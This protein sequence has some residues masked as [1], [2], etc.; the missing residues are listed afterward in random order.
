MPVAIADLCRV[1]QRFAHAGGNQRRRQD[2]L[3]Q[4][5]QERAHHRVIGHA[6]TDRAAVR[7]LEPSWHFAGGGQ[8]KGEASRG[9]QPYD[10][11]LPVVET[12]EVADVGEITAYERQVMS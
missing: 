5:V 1:V 6:D 12:R 9:S 4:L 8:E 11:E 10:T 7:V 3:A 2:R